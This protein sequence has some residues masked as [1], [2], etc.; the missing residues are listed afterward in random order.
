MNK[1]VW[2][3]NIEGNPKQARIHKIASLTSIEKGELVKKTGGLVVSY[4]PG[5]DIE[6]DYLLGVSAE[7]H[8]GIT[9]GRNTGTEIKIYDNPND[10]FEYI[11]K[12]V[13]TA[14]GGSET[15]FIDSNLK[16]KNDNDLEGGYLELVNCQ[17]DS[18][19][20]KNRIKINSYD[21]DTG[22]ITLA[23][24]LNS[25]LASGDTAYICPGRKVIN[26]YNF[27]L[28]SDGTGINYEEENSS[29]CVVEI[30]DV[31]VSKFAVYVQFKRSFEN[32]RKLLP[33]NLNDFEGTDVE[34]LQSAVD[35]CKLGNTEVVID[36]DIDLTGYSIN[37]DKGWAYFLNIVGINGAKLIK[38]DDGYIFTS[39][40]NNN[41]RGNITFRNLN[42]EG[43]I[44]K[45]IYLFDGDKLISVFVENCSFL[46]LNCVK[47]S[48][49]K[50]LQSLRLISCRI[51][52][53]LGYF[54]DIGKA[55][56]IHMSFNQV[57]ANVGVTD[58]GFVKIGDATNTRT[59]ALLFTFNDNLLEGQNSPL[60]VI[61]SYLNNF[62]IK[63][64]YF[65]YVS[66]G[67]VEIV[68]SLTAGSGNINFSC[69]FVS[70][71]TTII[72]GTENLIAD[73]KI[74]FDSNVISG[75]V[76]AINTDFVVNRLHISANNNSFK[77]HYGVT[78][79]HLITS[80]NVNLRINDSW[81]GEFGLSPVVSYVAGTGVKI[82]IDNFFQ[83]KNT[84]Y[85]G[86]SM[87][88]NIEQRH[89]AYMKGNFIGILSFTGVISTGNKIKMSLTTLFDEYGYAGTPT[90]LA[91]T[92]SFGNGTIYE[93]NDNTILTNKKIIFILAN[94]TNPSTSIAIK[95]IEIIQCS[96]ASE[97]YSR[98]YDEVVPPP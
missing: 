67:I 97:N 72:V 49:T 34:K 23:E 69:N 68:P 21:K 33:A 48:Q 91:V 70:D 4:A 2:T 95:P 46:Q 90:T 24:T 13:I 94:A 38:L 82:E 62:T 64:N 50:Y 6:H 43:D 18:R 53:H 55:Y 3:Y 74:T 28:N 81:V 12:E 93:T 9:T 22:T 41:Y 36:R 7:N 51:Y 89:T 45:Y 65:E 47:T 26:S 57:E 98:A 63:D 56:D 10:V 17:S 25:V 96:S 30:F 39:S 35:L 78:K 86:K 52:S 58:S 29:I 54:I 19:L 71:E 37:I 80:S 40:F 8:D 15:T 76:Y 20:N 44:S 32:L 14:T 16:F 87:I 31:D 42:L 92:A 85:A 83:A 59:G 77:D 11:T 66:G 61:P 84:N 75:N 73:S 27:A 5:I 79:N 1:F 60:F 88:V